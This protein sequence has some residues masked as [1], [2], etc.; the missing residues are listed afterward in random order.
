MRVTNI[1]AFSYAFILTSVLSSTFDAAV[2]DGEM[3]R[4]SSFE[5]LAETMD[6]TYGRVIMT[7]ALDCQFRLVAANFDMM[8]AS[9]YQKA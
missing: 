7:K 1:T 6:M 9:Y 2:M 5:E 3:D 8:P 4:D